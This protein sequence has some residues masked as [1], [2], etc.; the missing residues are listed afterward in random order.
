MVLII[1]ISSDLYRAVLV[2]FL[3][4]VAQ[5]EPMATATPQG[6]YSSIANLGWLRWHMLTCPTERLCVLFEVSLALGNNLQVLT[7]KTRIKPPNGH[8]T[9]G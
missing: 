1:P 4:I 9:V 3:C 6:G 5:S 7:S 2:C 8:P